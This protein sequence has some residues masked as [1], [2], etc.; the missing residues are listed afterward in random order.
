MMLAAEMFL[1]PDGTFFVQLINFAIFFAILSVVFLRPVSRAIR[2]R[3]AYINSVHDDY[4]KY[5][6]QASDL[7]AQAEAIRLS[8]R[9][10]A[11]AHVAKARAE[12]SNQSAA[13][14]A[15]YS[16]QVQATVED[17]HRKVATELDAARA[18]EEAV[19]RQLADLMLQR[20]VSE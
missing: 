15:Q 7:R 20:T 6:T 9:R 11:E 5:Q 17:A 14:V 2:E 10:E 19:V 3:R 8:A 16:S 18:G 12:A 13:I 4:E 1:Q